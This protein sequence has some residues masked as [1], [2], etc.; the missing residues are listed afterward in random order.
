MIGTL[1]AL[2]SENIRKVRGAQLPRCSDTQA[3]QPA[4]PAEYNHE[5][6]A[7]LS[8]VLRQQSASQK[9]GRISYAPAMLSVTEC[10]RGERS[11][12]GLTA[13]LNVATR[14]WINRALWRTVL[15]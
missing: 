15:R 12:L 9:T 6:F 2:K 5:R 7:P 3:P 13:L 11:H 14:R 1:P 10:E 4:A 8:L